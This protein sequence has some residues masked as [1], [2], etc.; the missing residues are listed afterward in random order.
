[1]TKNKVYFSAFLTLSL[2][3]LALLIGLGRWNDGV[4][5]PTVNSN[6]PVTV[7]HDVTM[8]APTEVAK[9]QVRVS[10]LSLKLHEGIY[11]EFETWVMKYVNATSVDEKKA[12]EAEGLTLATQ[13][14]KAL[15]KLIRL[16]P[17]HALEVALPFEAR[18]ELPSDIAK[19]LE[20]QIDK[21]GQ[22]SSMADMPNAPPVAEIDER[23]YLTYGKQVNSSASRIPLH[24]ISVDWS[25]AFSE[26][27]LRKL[28]PAEA[29]AY[30]AA[31]PKELPLSDGQVLADAGGS[32]HRFDS[33]QAYEAKSRENYTGGSIGISG[34]QDPQGLAGHDLAHSGKFKLLLMRIIFPDD[35]T[36]PITE[37]EA[38]KIL[39]EVNKY[40]VENSYGKFSILP[41]VT[42]LLMMPRV[43]TW[44]TEFDWT[45]ANSDGSYFHLLYNDALD[46]AAAAG[47][48]SKEYAFVPMRFIW[49]GSS[50]AKQGGQL[51]I[52]KQSWLK[53]NSGGTWAHEFGHNLG[54][55]H[56]N[57]WNAE[58]VDAPGGNSGG[59]NPFDTM[60]AGAGDSNNTTFGHN[61][62][63]WK[64][65]MTG[66]LPDSYI[67]Q[68][69]KSGTYRIYA[70]DYSRIDPAYKYAL[71]FQKDD[72]R[73]YYIEFRKNQFRDD[74]NLPNGICI[75]WQPWWG[76]DN[77]T[78]LL[79]LSDSTSG[80]VL[81]IGK[82]LSDTK[83]GINITPI[84]QGGVEPD[85]WVDVSINFGDSDA[86]NTSFPIIPQIGGISANP[87]G[88]ISVGTSVTFTVNAS[89]ADGDTLAYFWS[90]GDGTYDATNN[91]SVIHKFTTVGKYRTRCEV[92]DA[93]GK[94][95]AKSVVVSVGNATTFLV[96][97][98]VTWNGAPLLNARIGGTGNTCLT[99]S[100]GSYV[101]TNA[102]GGSPTGYKWGFRGLIPPAYYNPLPPS[103]DR[104]S[105][106]LEPMFGSPL[107][108]G[109]DHNA[110]NFKTVQQ[111]TLT[112]T[113]VVPNTI[114]KMNSVYV[115]PFIV[116]SIPGSGGGKGTAGN[117]RT[118]D[119]HPLQNVRFLPFKSLSG[120]YRTGVIGNQEK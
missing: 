64:N 25:A 41:T 24:G 36:E 39:S 62:V 46:V 103:D 57:S 35:E 102:N 72:Y 49:G 66:W 61:N 78:G 51:D 91:P 119:I 73:T 81:L 38:Y 109:Q 71:R 31:H 60:G 98:Q 106:S 85:Q 70:M 80:K 1:M 101:L 14:H 116:P 100:D 4:Q 52:K 90:F 89:D 115:N 44:Y 107:N 58:T 94:S 15:Y 117:F 77:G 87:S 21:M 95:A 120:H 29:T 48:D 76:N 50:Y 63:A 114:G 104:Y 84:A 79:N 19:Q 34:P 68:V 6:P 75:N 37:P 83:A 111:T 28:E 23:L 93:K 110:K 105:N 65:L 22:I 30:L 3:C 88:P 17:K 12:C 82:T 53:D 59:G 42:P 2:V 99:D 33:L 86:I 108:T 27:W 7:K 11:G 112:I 54:M 96:T 16:D 8:A 18:I 40:Y 13:R 92:T 5:P 97:G 56:S 32:V 74:K 9:P 45:D 55:G 20:K 43:K 118:P 69:G 47:F 10:K 67:N 113:Q 26:E